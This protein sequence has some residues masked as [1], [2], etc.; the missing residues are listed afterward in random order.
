M[1]FI[2]VVTSNIFISL[3][4]CLCFSVCLSLPPSLSLHLFLFSLSFLPALPSAKSCCGAQ[5]L[6]ELT[7]L[8]FQPPEGQVYRHLPWC[9][10]GSLV[11][12][13]KCEVLCT[14]GMCPSTRPHP[15]AHQE[16]LCCCCCCLFVSLFVF[17]TGSYYVDRNGPELRNILL[18]LTRTYM[19]P[20][21]V[22]HA[23]NL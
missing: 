23:C 9:L 6:L 17:E 10:T 3:S 20:D 16:L 1:K 15:Q 8:L 19:K 14:P 12:R 11:L 4:V 22:V 21:T 13:I 5:A 2:M 7:V 18:P